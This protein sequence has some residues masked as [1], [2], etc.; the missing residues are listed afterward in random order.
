MVDDQSWNSTPCF[1]S[2][3]NRNGAVV[4][5]FL[6]V[7]VLLI[8]LYVFGVEVS[9]FYSASAFDASVVEIRHEY[10]PAGRGSILAYVPVVETPNT[11]DRLNV[12][13]S[14][15]EDIYTIGTRMSVLCDLSTS[16]R[17]IKNTLFDA[18]GG[19]TVDL[20]L[21]S[22]F[23]ALSLFYYRRLKQEPESR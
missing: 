4:F 23:L 15:E 13:T 6:G 7:V 5:L 11:H 3:S 20:A 8:S 10:V 22:L 12:D 17:C 1:F 21:S 9:F 16:K 18:W 2:A 19:G 14:N